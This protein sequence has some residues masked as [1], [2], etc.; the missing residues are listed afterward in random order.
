MGSLHLGSSQSPTMPT[1]VSA[2]QTGF[3]IGAIF[4]LMIPLMMIAMMVKMMGGAFGEKPEA[5]TQG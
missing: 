2:A 4:N 5:E 3:D 1:Q